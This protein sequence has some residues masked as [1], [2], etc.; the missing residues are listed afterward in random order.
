MLISALPQEG[1]F[2][3]STEDLA[4]VE[5][6]RVVLQGQLPGMAMLRQEMFLGLLPALVGHPRVTFGK[7]T[8]VTVSTTGVPTD[9]ALPPR[10]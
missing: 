4:L 1:R 2:R 5:R 3:C 10:R 7:A 6:C 9:A 8:R